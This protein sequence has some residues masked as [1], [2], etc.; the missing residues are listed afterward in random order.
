MIE[1]GIDTS[2]F[3]AHSVRGV[4]C[5]K[6]AG[7]GVTTKQAADWSSEGTFQQFYHKRLE[8]EDKTSFGRHVLSSV[9]PSNNACWYETEL[10]EM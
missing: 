10:S 2:I 8:S 1:A 9:S 7:T 3:K 4:A 6:A 5:F